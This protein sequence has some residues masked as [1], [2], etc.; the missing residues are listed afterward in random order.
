MLVG[1]VPSDI[2]LSCTRSTTRDLTNAMNTNFIL[3]SPFKLCKKTPHSWPTQTKCKELQDSQPAIPPG[4]DAGQCRQKP[5]SVYETH[6]QLS[7]RTEKHSI[8]IASSKDT[9][10]PSRIQ[11]SKP[12]LYYIGLSQPPVSQEHFLR[13]SH[14][15]SK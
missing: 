1:L 12:A 15:K 6:S 4:A 13:K 5:V 14:V 10:D 9:R 11:Q 8:T 7:G 2:L 3:S